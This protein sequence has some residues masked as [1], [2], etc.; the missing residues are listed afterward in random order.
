MFSMMQRH[1]NRARDIIEAL[2]LL[3]GTSRHSEVM[4][5]PIQMAEQ[6]ERLKERFLTQLS[7]AGGELVAQE[8]WPTALGYPLWVE[9]IWA[10]YISNAIKYGGTPPRVGLGASEEGGQVRF[11]VQDNGDGLSPEQQACLFTP[12]TRLH[13]ER[14][15][16]HGLGLSIVQRISSRRGGEAGVTSEPGGGSRFWFTLP[17]H[18][19]AEHK[20]SAMGH[21]I[22]GIQLVD[23]RIVFQ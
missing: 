17:S 20:S 8:I 19:Q 21:D 7:E 9:E 14:A 1:V 2:L 10:N 13:R 6:V 23:G 3:A 16:G 22:S 5:E 4:I 15:E 18:A 11:W 12:F